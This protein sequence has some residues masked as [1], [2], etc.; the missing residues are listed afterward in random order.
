M[1]VDFVTKEYPPNI[2]GGAG[3][4][5]T[6]LVKVLRTLIEARVHAFGE[7]VTEPL[8]FGYPTPSEYSNSNAAIQTL[9][10]DLSIVGELAGAD[11]VH[12]HT[13]YANFAGQLGSLLH[14]IP[15]V[16]TAHSLEPL[17]PW[18]RE[19]LGGGY[20]VSS[21]IERSA[22]EQAKT[23]IAVSNGM[24]NDI[25]KAYPDLDPEKV[26]VVYNGIDSTKWSPVHDPDTV[27][28]LG[29][30]PDKRS[31]IFVGRITRQKGLP[32][33]LRAVRELP[34]D[35]QLV[36][37][38][39]APDTAEIKQEVE[40][41]VSEL[42]KTRSGVVWIPEHLPQPKLAALLTQADVFVCPS[43][44]EPLGIVNLEAMACGAAVVATATGGIPEV[45]VEGET[46]WLVPI[47][48]FDDGS[49][50]P[51]DEQK[52]VSDWSQTLNQALESGRL[53]EFGAAGRTRAIEKFSWE[54]IATRTLDVYKKTLNS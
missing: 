22:Y 50:T 34:A 32:Y 48:Q 4:H 15:H 1:R 39:G 52:F 35:V 20:A 33:F 14:G 43:I 37:C 36:L 28:S 25:L 13:W 44:Y 41:L 29:V 47:E 46:G 16:I 23:V 2:Y 6:E 5:I 31:V 40:Q 26:E 51:L 30:D 24:R 3:V 49:G 17:R 7:P 53:K 11:L 19:Q 27:R 18:K 54:S 12:S 9:G 21:F 10:I 42:S 38:A 8:T 45:V